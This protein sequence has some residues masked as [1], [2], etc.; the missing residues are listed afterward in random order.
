MACGM[1]EINEELWEFIA[2]VRAVAPPLLGA[3]RR[4]ILVGPAVEI[5]R[6]SSASVLSQL[7]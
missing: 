3:R 6:D 1:M 5:H 2:H 7:R 4:E